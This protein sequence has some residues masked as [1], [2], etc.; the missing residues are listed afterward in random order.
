[1]AK[2]PSSLQGVFWSVKPGDLDPEE[3]KVYI[4][5]QTLAYGG[6]EELRWLFK[7]HPKR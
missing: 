3:D 5:N 1:M 6:L 2:I 7:T 4:I